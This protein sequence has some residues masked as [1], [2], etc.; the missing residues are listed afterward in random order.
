MLHGGSGETLLNKTG[1]ELIPTGPW[2]FEWFLTLSSWAETFMYPLHT[3]YP[4]YLT[5]LD[6]VT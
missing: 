2:F 3:M 1:V 4:A 5:F 6:L